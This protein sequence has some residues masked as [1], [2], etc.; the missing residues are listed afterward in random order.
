MKTCNVVWKL[1][2]GNENLPLSFPDSWDVSTVPMR[3]EKPSSDEQI[4]ASL[5]KPIG[6]PLL[7]DIAKNK[8]RAVIAIDDLTRPTEDYRVLP[9]LLAELKQAGISKDNILILISLGAH[10]PLTRSDMEKK[11]GKEILNTYRIYNHSCF[12][13]LE[14]LGKTERGTPLH[15]NKF[16]LQADVRIGISFLVPHLLAGYSGGAKIVLPGMCGIDTLEYN[17]KSGVTGGGSN[18]LICGQEDVRSDMEEAARKAGLHFSVNLVGTSDG[19]TAAVFAGDV[20]AAHRAA[21][22]KA[23]EIYATEVPHEFDIA[24]LNAYPKDTEFMQC[25]NAFNMWTDAEQNIARPG[26][27]FVIISAAGEGKGTHFLSE[28]GMR[29]YT[30]VDN[31][32]LTRAKL[33][34][35]NLV[36]FSPNVSRQDVD[37]FFSGNRPHFTTWEE[38]VAHLEKN[39]GAGT[40]VGVFPCASMQIAYRNGKKM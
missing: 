12:E 8:Q 5:Q 2:H 26:G 15:V 21:V 39:Y 3:D 14:Y 19:K 7:S 32:P 28:P 40:E 18:A 27:T 29:L 16:F 34:D 11:V 30:T 22:E 35:R 13:N 17:H 10:R 6:S 23:D 33:K 24:I 37:D 1:W 38:T 36:I 31:F 20:V 9:F 25:G 4:R